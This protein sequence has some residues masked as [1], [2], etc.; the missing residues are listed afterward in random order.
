MSTSKHSTTMLDALKS[1]YR[2][3][4][5]V[6][7]AN[8][9]VYLLNPVGIGEHPDLIG[10][11]DTEMEKLATAEEKLAAAINLSNSLEED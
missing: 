8:V 7:R 6:A 11:I 4:A 10:A 1:K 2:A 9:M 3:E 5:E